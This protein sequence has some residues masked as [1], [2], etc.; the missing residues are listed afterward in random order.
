MGSFVLW[1]K[2]VARRPAALCQL[3]GGACWL[4]TD[5]HS[6]GRPCSVCSLYKEST[7][8]STAWLCCVFFGESST[9][10]QWAEVF[11]LLLLMMSNR[12]HLLNRPY[13]GKVFQEVL[14]ITDR[15]MCA[16]MS[17]EEM[18]SRITEGVEKLDQC[19]FEESVKL[20]M[21]QGNVGWKAGSPYLSLAKTIQSIQNRWLPI[22]LKH[23]P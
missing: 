12:C 2:G 19:W 15:R 9:K 18:A 21:V 6:Y 20:Q 23:S 7:V 10:T 5:I 16:R 1:Y 17:K 3:L 8:P 22:S 11:A 13:D 4:C 14:D